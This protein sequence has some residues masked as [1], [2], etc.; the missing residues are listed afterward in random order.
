M[1]VPSAPLPEPTAWTWVALMHT[2]GPAAAADV[3]IHEQP[4][5]AEHVAFLERMAAQGLLVAAGPLMDQDGAGMTVLKL[6][7][8]MQLDEAD[9]LATED[10]RSVAQGLLKVTVRPWHVLRSPRPAGWLVP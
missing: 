2:P 5:F 7:G 6:P 4:L 8:E 10:D 1:G 3:P 9:R